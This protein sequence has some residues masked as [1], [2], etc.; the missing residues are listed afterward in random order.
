MVSSFIDRHGDRLYCSIV[1]DLLTTTLF[2]THV[3]LCSLDSL[4][5]G[6][7]MHLP[8]D[9]NHPKFI[10]KPVGYGGGTFMLLI[11]HLSTIPM[12]FLIAIDQL[13]WSCTSHFLAVISGITATS[14][15]GG[16]G[17]FCFFRLCTC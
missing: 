14:A 13:S 8:I 9:H 2:D 15:Y 17:T 16:S 12:G 10:C 7:N 6:T 1:L 5:Y 11:S 4:C 3:L